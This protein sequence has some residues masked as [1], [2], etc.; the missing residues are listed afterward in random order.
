MGQKTVIIIGSGFAGLSAA[1]FMA[2]AGWKVTVLEKHDIPGGRARQLKENGFTFDMGP[3]FYWMP[4]VFDRYFEKFDRKTTDYYQLTR[5]DPSYRIYWGNDFSDIPASYTAVRDLFEGIEPGS[6]RKLD[7]Y[8]AGAAYKYKVGMGQLVYKPGLSFSEFLDWSTIRGITKLQVFTSMRSHIRKYF[9]NPRLQQLME[10]P[11]LFLGALPQDTPALYSLMNYADIKGGTWYP[12]GGMYAVAD[13]MYKLAKELNVAFHFN[14]TATKISVQHG[15][16]HGVVTNTKTWQADAVIS[17]ADYQFTE[18]ALLLP[19]YRTYTDT[20][21]DSRVMAPSCLLYY[22]GL[23]RKLKTRVHHSLF[24]DVPFD[25]HGNEI[26]KVPQWPSA[27]LFYV[28]IPSASEAGMAPE[29]SENLVF[30]VPVASGLNGDDEQLREKYFRMIIARMEKET[31]EPIL[32]AVCYRK[33]YSVSDFVNDYNAYRGNAYGLANTLRQT[34]IFR[35]SCKS[36][37]VRNL[38][39]TGQLTVPGPGVPPS[40]V[41]GEVVAKQLIK[42]L[43]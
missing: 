40:L 21:W 3:S 18:K 13:G 1:S 17:A 25:K 5:L 6:A 12:T 30:L 7:K 33:T 26:Y 38:F 29:G 43:Q 2:K 37:K 8:L 9:R 24:F 32:D 20:Y 16:A 10:F 15:I 22:V 35:P 42:S 14:E 28:S 34:A 31:G 41:S 11:I 27:P 39:F 36:K 4:D 23:N 19:E